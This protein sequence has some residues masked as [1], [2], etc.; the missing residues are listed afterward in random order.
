MRTLK[1]LW[2]VATNLD[3]FYMVRVATLLRKYR[4]DVEDVSPD[5]LN[6][7]EQLAAIRRRSARQPRER[8]F[9]VLIVYQNATPTLM[10]RTVGI[11]SGASSSVPPNK[12]LRPPPVLMAKSAFAAKQPVLAPRSGAK[13]YGH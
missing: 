4:N 1:F 7:S 10:S 2:I 5:E 12:R 8:A 11:V 3:A 9:I 6:T 13:R